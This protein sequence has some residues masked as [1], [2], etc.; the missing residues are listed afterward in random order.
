MCGNGLDDD[1]DG[2][3]DEGCVCAQGASQDCYPGPTRLAGVGTCA[4]GKQTCS[5]EPE[6]GGWGPC[7]DAVTPAPEACDGL[8]NDCDG[9]VDDGCLCDIGAKRACYAGP[10]GTGGVGTCRDGTQTCLARRR[11]HRQLLGR[12]RGDVRP[13]R[14]LCD[15]LDND[16][17]GTV[18]D[19]CACTRGRQ[20]RLLRRPRRTQGV[21]PCAAGRQACV[22]KANGSEWGPCEGQTLPR[23]E[24]CDGIDNDCD[25]TVDD[26]CA[27]TAGRDARLLRRARRHPPR[28][29]LRR[30]LADLRRGRGRRR[31][32]L[33][34][35][36]RRRGCPAPRRC[37]G[38]DD[39]CDGIVD[40]G[41]ACRR[42]ETRA[43]Y[44]GAGRDRGRRR[45][46]RGHEPA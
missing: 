34:R 17:N 12:V 13:D 3:V 40:D 41:C 6:F 22:T 18:D 19:G 36:Q 24:L 7:E 14:D 5:G 32:R 20:P 8:D 21:G 16:C 27:C 37:N 26:G 42:G 2:R 25:G 29:D 11:R 15:G 28:R 9:K 4:A 35:V 38:L 43:C 45:L 10:A 33:G 44:D 23:P 39:D 31:Q 1:G 30:R 46:P